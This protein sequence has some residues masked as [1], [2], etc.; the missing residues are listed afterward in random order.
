MTRGIA[1]TRALIAGASLGEVAALLMRELA[2]GM[3]YVLLGYCL[4]RWIEIQ[5]KRKG[6][7]ETVSK[8]WCSTLPWF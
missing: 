1:M 2:I 6:T 3:G 4:F 8:I 7:L 5:A